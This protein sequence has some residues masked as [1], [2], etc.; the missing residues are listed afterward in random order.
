MNKTL[1]RFEEHSAV[2]FESIDQFQLKDPF[3]EL[4]KKILFHP[5]KRIMRIDSNTKKLV[6]IIALSDLFNY[7]V[8]E[9]H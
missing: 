1:K 4:V 3:V 7:F 9:E 8:T 6:D 5:G 2:K